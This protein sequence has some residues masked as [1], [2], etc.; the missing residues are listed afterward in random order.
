MNPGGSK[1]ALSVKVLRS[2]L[3]LIRDAR[4]PYVVLNIAYYG[5]VACAL[6]YTTFDRSLQQTL[7]EAVGGALAEGPLAPVWDAYSAQRVLL[8]IG[9]TF[10]INLIVGSFASITLPS[11][12]I[13]FSGSLVAGIR[14]LT[15][16][17]LFSPQDVAGVGPP[18]LVAGFLLVGLLFLE[19][20]G[21]VLALFGAYLHGR[22]FLWPQ[23][24]GATGRR[25]GYWHGL[26]QQGHIYLLVALVLIIAALYEVGLAM[27]AI[28]VLLH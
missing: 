8:A 14:P 24:V 6:V 18:E 2:A 25:Q 5:L 27:V 4:R 9:L 7:M 15:W 22:A 19:G 12:V 17:V 16:G 10:G 28:P 1:E 13:P 26:K 23:S 20:Q 11:L 3:N 21:Y